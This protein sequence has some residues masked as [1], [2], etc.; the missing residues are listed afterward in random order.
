MAE[1]KW[2]LQAV[3]D[4]DSIAAFIAKDSFQYARLFVLDIFQ[5]VD[6]IGDFPKS[7]R[8]VPELS[9][10]SVREV[11]LGNYRIVYRHKEDLVELLTIY[12]AARLLDQ[13]RLR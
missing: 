13:N 3:G 1:V 8:M 5:A 6:R 12:H 11:I 7:G 4:L 2:T 10:P 9:I